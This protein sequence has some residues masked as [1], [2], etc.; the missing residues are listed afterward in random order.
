M[1]SGRTRADAATN[2]LMDVGQISKQ[3]D[4][5]C[6]SF[7][8]HVRT[9]HPSMGTLHSIENIR[10]SA[11]PA[12]HSRE[13]LYTADPI[14]HRLWL[15]GSRKISHSFLGRHSRPLVVVYC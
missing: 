3:N 9:C 1:T 12:R 7:I 10:A 8:N 11:G 5:Y 2:G 14:I 13:F 6:R 15:E 4:F